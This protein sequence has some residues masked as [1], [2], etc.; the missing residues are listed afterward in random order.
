MTMEEDG[1]KLS[2]GLLQAKKG[3]QLIYRCFYL[4]V[5]CHAASGY[6]EHSHQMDF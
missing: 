6:Y 4:E 3:Q 5:C 2:S 1:I